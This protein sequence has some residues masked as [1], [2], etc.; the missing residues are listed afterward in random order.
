MSG[1]MSLTG[2]EGNPTRFGLPIG[3]LVGGLYGAI[4]ILGA[5]AE[6]NKSGKGLI[7]DLSLLDGIVSLLGY[8]AGEYF[9]T[10]K[11]GKAVGSHHPFIVPYGTYKV[12]DGAIVLGVYTE[13][14][15]EKFVEAIGKKEWLMDQRFARNDDRVKNKEILID[16][17]QNILGKM[18]IEE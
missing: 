1:V 6:K 10:G 3:D 12:K 14:F 17:V 5:I 16:L 8:F 13:A 7:I 18:T 9:L 4:S 2:E 11:P 15:W